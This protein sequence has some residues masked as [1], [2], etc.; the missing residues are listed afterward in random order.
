MS[1]PRSPFLLAVL[2]FAGTACIGSGHSISAYGGTRFLDANELDDV[3]N[4]L[5][6]GLD[7]VLKFDL[8]WLGLEGGWLHAEDDDDTLGEL[9][10]DEYF[11]GLRVTPWK[12]LVQPYGAVGVTYVDSG[13]D[14]PAPA[15]DG[16]D[17]EL[18]YY[19][20]VGAAIPLGW[21]R[22]GLDWRFLAGTDVDLDTVESDVDGHQ[23]TA[24]IGLGF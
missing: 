19:G 6:Y 13:L 23:L 22:F 21:L 7:G 10:L 4:P 8:P 20:R 11:L 5:V 17:E 1:I 3:D 24:F 12:I 14:A 16:D 2:A 15:S 18:A 9:V